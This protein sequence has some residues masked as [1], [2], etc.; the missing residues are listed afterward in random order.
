MSAKFDMNAASCICK[1]CGRAYGQMKGNFRPSYAPLYRGSGFLP[2]CNECVEKM[3]TDYLSETKDSKMSTRQMCRKLDLY[4]SDKIFNVVAASNTNRSLMTAYISKINNAYYAGKSY[5]DTLRE[6]GSLWTFGKIEES[7]TD[8]SNQNDSKQQEDDVNPV[9]DR[10]G[11]DDYE[12]TDDVIAFWGP[13]YSNSMYRELQDRWDYYMSK[14]LGDQSIDI[15]TEL[16]IKQ[17]CNLEIDINRDRV[18]GKPVDKYIGQLNQL[19]G[20][21]NFKPAQKKEEA[22]ENGYDTTPFGVW[23]ERWERERP[24]PEIDD[25]LK[26]VN[27]LKRYID[28][29]FRGHLAKM[30]GIK[31]GMSTMYEEEIKRLRIEKP[32]FDDEDDESY[33]YDFFSNLGDQG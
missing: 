13:G 29:W 16:L 5:D 6:D 25:D 30:L 23:I 10:Q 18:S 31:N 9:I 1:R 15:G 32:E 8:S 20:S 28:I 12:P 4:W 19:L 11:D 24:V 33:V 26:D 21:L 14:F 2:Y 7:A 27:K 17:I 3:F 22:S